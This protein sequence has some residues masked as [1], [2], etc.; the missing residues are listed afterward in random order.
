MSNPMESLDRELSK[1]IEDAEG[2][3]TS[4]HLLIIYA[5][6]GKLLVKIIRDTHTSETET[7]EDS[8]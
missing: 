2:E 1:I 7:Q 3:R 5:Y 6:L 4:H 8:Q